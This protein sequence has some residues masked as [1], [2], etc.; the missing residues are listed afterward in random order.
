MNEILPMIK[1]IRGLKK[2]SANSFTLVELLVVISIIGLLAGLAVPAIQGGLDKAK[3]GVDVSNA[4]QLGIIFFSEAND[5]NGIYR[6][7]GDLTNTTVANNFLSIIQGMCSNGVL[8]S[9]KILSGQG[10]VPAISTNTITAANIAFGYT[11]NL[12]TSDD[13]QIPLILTKGPTS[14]AQSNITL[15][16]IV[17]YRLGNSAEFIKSGA[18]G[19]KVGA[20]NIGVTNSN[21][22]LQP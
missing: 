4:R 3:Q 11:P 16:K 2:L 9:A 1:M 10:V 15:A 13:G 20:V 8:T 19:A 5:N 12:T 6:V 18:N 21:T 7:N 17:V 14:L 22:V